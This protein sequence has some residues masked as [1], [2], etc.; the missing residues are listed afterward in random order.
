MHKG[1]DLELLRASHLFLN[2]HQRPS[3]FERA[4]RSLT[5]SWSL[6]FDFTDVGRLTSFYTDFPNFVSCERVY[7]NARLNRNPNDERLISRCGRS[8]K[9]PITVEH[10]IW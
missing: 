3:G 8:S 7:L 5:F 1:E 10:R 4:R 2:V 6:R 9:A